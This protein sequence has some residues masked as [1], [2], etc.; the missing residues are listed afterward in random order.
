MDF[1]YVVYEVGGASS[2]ET[3]FQRHPGHEWGYVLSGT[4]SVTIGFD[5]Y[6]LRP[7]DSISIDS[8]VPHR[9]ANTGDEPAHG[10]WFT[11]GRQSHHQP[12]GPEPERGTAWHDPRRGPED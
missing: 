4:L 12:P 8:M 11:T 10:I 7:G 2:P 3:A 9:L 6:V 1:L 5:E